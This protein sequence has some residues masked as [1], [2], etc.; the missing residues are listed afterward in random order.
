MLIIFTHIVMVCPP[1]PKNNN[2]GRQNNL[3]FLT[4]SLSVRFFFKQLSPIPRVRDKDISFNNH[5]L[6]THKKGWLVNQFAMLQGFLRPVLIGT[7]Y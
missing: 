4:D 7:G 2:E 1:P 5:P 3:G 6:N